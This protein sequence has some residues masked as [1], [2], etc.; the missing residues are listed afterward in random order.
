MLKMASKQH[1]ETLLLFLVYYDLA[2][3]Q[4]GVDKL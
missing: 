2:G 3:N 1:Y 4:T